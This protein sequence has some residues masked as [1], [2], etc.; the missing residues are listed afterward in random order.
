M[1]CKFIL[2]ITPILVQKI[3]KWKLW[4][5]KVISLIKEYYYVTDN[6]IVLNKKQVFWHIALAFIYETT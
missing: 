5:K 3:E 4:Q 1:F 6:G 2:P